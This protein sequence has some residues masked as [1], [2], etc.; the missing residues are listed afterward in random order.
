MQPTS[1]RFGASFT[2][3]TS[4]CGGTTKTVCAAGELDL[5]VI[6]HLVASLDDI[7][8]TEPETLVVDLHATTFIDVTAVRALLAARRRVAARRVRL[9]IIPAPEHVHRVFRLCGV[10]GALPFASGSTGADQPATTKPGVRSRPDGPGDSVSLVAGEG[11]D[12]HLG[13][14]RRPRAATRLVDHTIDSSL[15][16]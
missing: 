6:E 9:V 8:R 16:V 1:T 7:L 11:T 13:V 4:V 10:E 2:V 15:H 14:G 12:R 3:G 5:A